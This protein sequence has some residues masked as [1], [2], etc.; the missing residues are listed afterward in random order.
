MSHFAVAVFRKKG[1]TIKGLLLPF[2]EN[3]PNAEHPEWDFYEIGGRYSGRLL[4]KNGKR[5]NSAKVS[6]I[7]FS[8]DKEAYERAI[9]RWE[10]VVEKGDVDAEYYIA[11]Y[12]DK[13]GYANA[14]AA[15]TTF[16]V[17]TPDGQWHDYGKLSDFG[18]VVTRSE[19]EGAWANN[20][21]SRFIDTADPEWRLTIV[22]CHI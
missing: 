10:N 4:K 13:E 5:V 1:Q 15:F 6:E 3:N 14:M 2:Y 9:K 18:F 19:T 17:V 20:Y 12:S 11:E 22:D 7:D 8:P 21:K 16:A